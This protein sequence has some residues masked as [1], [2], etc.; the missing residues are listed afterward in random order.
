M[1]PN[2]TAL[3]PAPSCRRPRTHVY[4]SWGT[5]T[6]IHICVYESTAPRASFIVLYAAQPTSKTVRIRLHRAACQRQ[7]W[8]ITLAKLGRSECVPTRARRSTPASFSPPPPAADAW[9]TARWRAPPPACCA[10]AAQPF[11]RVAACRA[12]KPA[13]WPFASGNLMQSF[14]GRGE[15]RSRRAGGGSAC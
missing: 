13:R 10:A 14:R 12:A 1:P 2:A 15:E 3:P 7:H 9:S 4:T 5:C 8:H 11:H 6:R